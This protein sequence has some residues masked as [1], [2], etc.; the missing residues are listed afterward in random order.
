LRSASFRAHGRAAQ[1]LAS[2]LEA[3]GAKLGRRRASPVVV[4]GWIG[5]RPTTIVRPTVPPPWPSLVFANGAT[6]EGRTH[7]TVLKLAVALARSGYGVYIPDLPGVADGVLTPTTLAA[8][9]ESTLAAADADATKD[10]RV[11][12]VGVSIGGTLALLVAADPRLAARVS[13]VTCIAPFTDLER[14][15]LLATTGTYRDRKGV[16]EP[17]PVPAELAAGLARS[18]R[19]LG[20]VDTEPSIRQ[21]LA[22]RD[23]N[24]F[25]ELYADL[26][27]A[28]HEA[29]IALSPRHSAARIEA[30]VEIAT[31]P[32]DRYFPVAESLALAPNP[33][34]RI[35]VTPTLAHAIPHFDP[36]N[37]VGLVRLE[38]FFARSL[39][40]SGR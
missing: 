12:L 40:L 37:L 38:R 1:V 20:S 25:D 6:S 24:R 23:P 4:E 16:A 19:E 22:N 36:R 14:V 5:G 15:I 34:V 11:G 8:A 33:R 27:P 17:Y 32:R 7:A 31:A 29:V 28:V 13:V 18:I 39:L 35:T 3:P 26:P 30:P 2:I 9:V 10:G 21:L